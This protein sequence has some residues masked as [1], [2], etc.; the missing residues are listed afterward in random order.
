MTQ[1]SSDVEIANQGFAAF[2]QDLNDVLEDITT[3]HSGDTAPSTT[4]AN[5]WWYET[6][7]D[8]LYI[9][10]EDNDAWIELFNLDQ[11]ND[12]IA[13]LDLQGGEL[14]LDDDGDTSITADTDDQIDFRAGGSDIA[15]V[16]A[17]GLGIGATPNKLVDISAGDSGGDPTGNQPTLRITNT[18]NGGWNT[19]DVIGE[20]E[21]FADD[22]SG[23]LASFIKSEQETNGGSVTDGA[24]TFGTCTYGSTTATERMRIDSS[25]NFLLGKTSTAVATVGA[26]IKPNG[27]YFASVNGSDSY[28]TYDASESRYEFYVRGNGGIANYSSNN[29]NLSDQ[30]EK[31]NIT[32]AASAWDDVKGFAV[33]EFHYNFEDDADPKQLGVIAQDVQVNHPDLIKSFKIDDSTTKLGVIEQQITWMAIKALQEA[34][35]KIETLETKVATLETQ[36]TDFETRIAALESA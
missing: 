34:M 10:N 3:L 14:I 19:G 28:H 8:K 17:T 4:Y 21:F 32:A 29:L 11:V 24:L 6:D 27:Q 9:R 31:K 33:K 7:T 5:Q 26:M 30:T 13:S 1:N 23:R 16:T 22:G 20:I 35:T 36:A 15:H 2:R 18:T 12:K 25:G